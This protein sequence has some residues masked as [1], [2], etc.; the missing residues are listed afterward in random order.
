M[1]RYEILR[2]EARHRTLPRAHH[3]AERDEGGTLAA[4]DETGRPVERGKA[5]VPLCL[6][7]GIF[8]RKA[9]ERA[10]A[11]VDVAEG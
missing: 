3:N 2:G 5:D 1:A 8:A 7:K 11:R 10:C 6:R 9:G 4:H